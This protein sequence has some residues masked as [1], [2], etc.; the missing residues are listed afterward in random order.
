[1]QFKPLN[2]YFIIKI[3]KDIQKER[4]EKIGSIYLHPYYVYMTRGCQA[5]EIVAI[6]EKAAEYFPEAKIGDVALLH[7]FSEGKKDNKGRP[8][9]LITEDE[10]SNYYGIKGVN[11]D[12]DRNMVFAIWDGTELIP[13]KDHVILEKEKEPESDLLEYSMPMMLS[14][15][16]LIIPKPRKKTRTELIAQMTVNK[17]KIF[18]LSTER[19]LQLKHVKEEIRKLEAENDQLSR[20]VNHR[21][22]EP[23]KVLFFNPELSEALPLIEKGSYV[24]TLNIASQYI[25]EFMGIEYIVVSVDYIGLLLN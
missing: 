23:Y 13:N 18:Q 25:I 3:A 20:Q 21:Q 14:Q 8:F 6:G 15:G 2:N 16:G 19:L 22:Y 24:Y 7:H 12:G 4:Q 11:S 1:M 5:A 10:N 17:K 9:Y